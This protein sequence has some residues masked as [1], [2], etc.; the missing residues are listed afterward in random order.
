M[1]QIELNL[2]MSAQNE[3]LVSSM[4]DRFFS[5]IVDKPKRE[6]NILGVILSNIPRN[7]C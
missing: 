3:S 2:G 4:S 5:S 1:G 6:G 7:L